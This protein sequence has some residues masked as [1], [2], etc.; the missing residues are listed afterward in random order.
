MKQLTDRQRE[1]LEFIK[2]YINKAGYPPSWQ[3]IANGLGI[4]Q[5]AVHIK[6]NALV[7][8]GYIRYDHYKPRTLEVHEMYI[9][10]ADVPELGVA[11][12]DYLHIKNG[13]SLTAITRP[14]EAE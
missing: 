11:E 12:G 5:A 3:E 10:E 13:R 4:T 1:L 9:A 14:L 6:I 7:K 2:A 8:K